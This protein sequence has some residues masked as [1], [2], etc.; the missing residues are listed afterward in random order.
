MSQQDLAAVR[1]TLSALFLTFLVTASLLASIVSPPRSFPIIQPNPDYHH[2][3]DPHQQGGKVDALAE[4]AKK[5]FSDSWAYY[6]PY[7]PAAHF[8]E[9]GRMREGCVVSQ[10]NIVS[11]PTMPQS[12]PTQFPSFN[13]MVPGTLL[14]EQWEQSSLRSQ[15]SRLP[16]ATMIQ[17]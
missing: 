1:L 3:N 2:A 4:M 13:V 11:H 9:S 5:S 7:Y 12:T 10:V 15:S 14:Q 8:E 16:R 17:N 6:A